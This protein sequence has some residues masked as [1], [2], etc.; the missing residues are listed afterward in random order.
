VHIA[1]GRAAVV[2]VLAPTDIVRAVTV[3]VDAGVGSVGDAGA[4]GTVLALAVT[5]AVVTG[6]G[7]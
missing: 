4:V 3:R 1:A 7:S 5:G 6:G 2:L